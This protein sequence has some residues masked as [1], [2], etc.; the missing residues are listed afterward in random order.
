MSAPMIGLT[1]GI[2][3]GKSVVARV[4]A[5][6]GYKVV[7]TDGLARR[8]MDESDS[9]KRR[10]AAEIDD[11]CIVDGRIDR[12]RLAGVVFADSSR[13]AILNDIVHGIVRAELEA[14]AARATSF[15]FVETAIFASSGLWRMC[16]AELRVD[17]PEELRVARVMRRSGITA[18][19]V[20]A[21]IAAQ[22][23]EAKLPPG[24]PPVTVITNDGKHPILPQLDAF[25]ARLG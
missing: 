11:A 22:Q 24:S 21:R 2:G 8:L 17:A 7:D 14:M 6:R 13:L 25:L 4:L 15:F 23:S 18:D 5:V 9:V 12:R 10:I 20:R 16:A 19:E 1:G 3:S